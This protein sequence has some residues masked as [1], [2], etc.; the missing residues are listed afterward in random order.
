MP[1]PADLRLSGKE[2]GKEAVLSGFSLKHNG[3]KKELNKDLKISLNGAWKQEG[4][5]QVKGSVDDFA[6]KLLQA[7]KLP[8]PDLDGTA[9][10]RFVAQGQGRCRIRR[11]FPWTCPNSL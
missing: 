1:Q 9:K 4:G 10:A 5:W 7:W 11:N 6:L 8:V 2:S 3:L